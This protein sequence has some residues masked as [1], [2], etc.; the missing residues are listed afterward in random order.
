MSEQRIIRTFQGG[1]AVARRRI[2]KFGSGD[3][4]VVQSSAAGDLHLGIATELDSDSGAPRDV[5]LFGETEV[6]YGG[7]VP[8]GAY[9]T[10]DANGKAVACAPAAGVKAQAIG[11]AL[12]T[13]ADGDIGPAFVLRSQVTTPA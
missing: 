13:A 8:R 2:V 5:V 6:E 1:A 10:A 4:L 9:F 11:I 3:G 7:A 12:F